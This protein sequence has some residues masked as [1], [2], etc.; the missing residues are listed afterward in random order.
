MAEGRI[1]ARAGENR[2]LTRQFRSGQRKIPLAGGLRDRLPRGIP[3]FPLLQKDFFLVLHV[4]LCCSP[5]SLEKQIPISRSTGKLWEV[6]IEPVEINLSPRT[7]PNTRERLI[8]P[9]THSKVIH[10]TGKRSVPIA[11]T[12]LVNNF[13]AG[14]T[15]GAQTSATPNSF[16]WSSAPI[17]AREGAGHGARGARAFR[18]TAS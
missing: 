11:A 14:Q 6:P 16:E 7:T 10:L 12:R 18:R 4:A 3:G 8:R 9:D 1:L 5:F 15:E 2:R 13:A 17:V